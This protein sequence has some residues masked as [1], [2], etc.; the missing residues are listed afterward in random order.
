MKLG[1]SP[2]PDFETPL[3]LPLT[4]KMNRTM[5]AQFTPI[6]AIAVMLARLSMIAAC[7]AA[8]TLLPAAAQTADFVPVSERIAVFD[9]DGTLWPENPVPFQ[10]AFASYEITRLL[11]DHPEWNDDPAI[12]AFKKGD[13]AALLADHARGLLR[14]VALTHAGMT[15]EEFDQR[16]KDWVVK[17]RHPRF[18]RPYTA[19][20]YQ[21]MLELLPISEPTA[22]RHGRPGGGDLRVCPRTLRHSSRASRRLSR[23]AE[24][25]NEGREADAHQDARYGLRGRQGG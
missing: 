10:L 15:T 9:N 24:I 22:S 17:D 12:Q 23:A 25:C 7:L 1:S 3:I 16:V 18:E 11:P 13:L 20:I 2:S 6:A 8:G 21:P 4:H 5:N 14:I 19:C